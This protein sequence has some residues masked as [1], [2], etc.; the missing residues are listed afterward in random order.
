MIK[1][2]LSLLATANSEILAYKNSS[3]RNYLYESKL[4]D[5]SLKLS[6]SQGVPGFLQLSEPIH[7]CTSPQKAAKL[8]HNASLVNLRRTRLSWSDKIVDAFCK[9]IGLCFETKI[10]N[11]YFTN[12]FLLS[13]RGE[14]NV[15]EKARLA[16][17]A[18]Y[19]GLIV[20]NDKSD[21]IIH[22]TGNDSDI[23]IPVAFT[24][25]HTGI[26]LRS[27]FLYNPRQ[28]HKYLQPFV[29][30][31]GDN[32]GPISWLFP[33]TICAAVLIFFLV[34]YA[35]SKL[36]SQYKHYRK[37]YL[38]RRR[39]KKLPK[40]KWSK[41]SGYETC[42]ICI[43]DY[44][45]NDLL[46]ILPCNHAYHTD[47]IDPW[48]IRS[49]R[50]CPL[51]KQSVLSSEDSDSDRTADPLL[52]PSELSSVTSTEND[53]QNL[54]PDDNFRVEIEQDDQLLLAGDRN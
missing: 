43:E 35:C 44:E 27:N 34:I 39:L 52:G 49:K 3:S 54:N 1:L 20:Y 36:V 18:G 10:N 6:P 24:S 45:T 2:L 19:S 29:I 31:S 11:E 23:R 7:T 40:K 51:C 5:F 17:K 12:F 25:L 32:F 37:T 21:T 30:I 38:T 4:A 47:C 8:K 28:K 41:E 50:N 16:Q 26:A 14:C 48:L 15:I 33:I 22:V 46:R 53:E 9:K 13:K 42:A